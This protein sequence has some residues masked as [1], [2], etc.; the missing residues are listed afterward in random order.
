MVGTKKT[1]G[2]PDPCSI[3]ANAREPVILERIIKGGA[4]TLAGYQKYGGYSALEKVRSHPAEETLAEIEASNLRG[5]GGAG[6]PT[7]RKWR[8]VAQQPAGVKYVVCPRTLICF[9]PRQKRFAN[10]VS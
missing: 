6:F 4:R 2:T 9:R 10:E 3:S 5:R 1:C 7:G 8:A